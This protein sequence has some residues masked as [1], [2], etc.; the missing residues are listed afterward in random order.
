ME[1]VNLN[2]I[3]ILSALNKGKSYDQISA[4]K[5]GLPNNPQEL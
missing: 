5:S 1:Y 3:D 4:T 2:G